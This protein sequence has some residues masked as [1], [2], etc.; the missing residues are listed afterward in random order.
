MMLYNT[1]DEA[2]IR[3]N[4]V[5]KWLDGDIS[6]MKD[7]TLNAGYPILF[8]V[9]AQIDYLATL[10]YSAKSARV[11]IGK[12]FNEFMRSDERSIYGKSL[13]DYGL[14]LSGSR[15]ANFGELMYVA[16]RCKLVHETNV[17]PPFSVTTEFPEDTKG[18]EHLKP[19][20]D[21]KYILVFAYQMS[22]DFKASKRR[23]FDKLNSDSDFFGRIS[24]RL[25]SDDYNFD[26][27][28]H[29]ASLALHGLSEEM[30]W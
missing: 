25:T 17:F 24:K 22:E 4:N 15:I 27:Y 3:I 10:I 19:T 11:R 5:L 13:K 1:Q 30:G 14:M 6:S 29:R 18:K 26:C 16:V 28:A 21:G 7:K 2:E 23:F 8:C 9:F 12:Y 20:D